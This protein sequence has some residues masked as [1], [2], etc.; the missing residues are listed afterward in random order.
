MPLGARRFKPL[1]R[2]FSALAPEDTDNMKEA[3]KLH[4]FVQ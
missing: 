3:R 2:L 1:L 4:G